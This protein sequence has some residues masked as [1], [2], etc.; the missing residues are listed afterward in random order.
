VY[1]IKNRPFARK[2]AAGFLGLGGL[3]VLK[4][5]GCIAA[6]DIALAVK[7]EAL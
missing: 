7:A 6:L 3:F 5:I 1:Q 2:G 4:A